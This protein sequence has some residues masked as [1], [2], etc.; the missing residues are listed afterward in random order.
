MNHN[1]NAPRDPW[2]RL[3]TAARAVRDE[4]DVTAPYGFATRVAALALLQERSVS[5]LFERFALRAL[6]VAS[7]LALGSLALNYNAI[8]N[9][10]PS[11][12]AASFANIDDVLLPTTDAVAVV[13]DLAD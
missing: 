4:R 8:T 5:S 9:P 12:A 2:S 7:L 6:G 13:L 11:A 3:T 10:A 1:L